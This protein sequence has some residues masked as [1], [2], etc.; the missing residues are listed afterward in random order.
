MEEGT[1]EDLNENS[2]FEKAGGKE[3]IDEVTV[4]E[5]RDMIQDAIRAVMGG[6]EGVSGEEEMDM[7]VDLGG[8]DEMDM[9]MDLEAGEEEE[10]EEKPKKK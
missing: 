5:L 1:D 7:D 9:D 8:E 4:D 10:T 2:M 6:E 3:N